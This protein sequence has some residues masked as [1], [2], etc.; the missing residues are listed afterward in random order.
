MYVIEVDKNGQVL[1]VGDISPEMYG[2]LAGTLGADLKEVSDFVDRI[3]PDSK[4]YVT[5][6]IKQKQ[7]SEKVFVED[8]KPMYYFDHDFKRFKINRE[9]DPKFDEVKREQW[10]NKVRKAKEEK[11]LVKRKNNKSSSKNSGNRG[12]AKRS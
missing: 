10:R 3:A 12:R 8:G 11:G 2:H 1:Q 5:E 6:Q 4:I 9:N 7:Y